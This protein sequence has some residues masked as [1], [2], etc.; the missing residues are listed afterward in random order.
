MGSN[1]GIQT[2]K[3]QKPMK[4]PKPSALPLRSATR[5]ALIAGFLPIAAQGATY[6][7]NTTPG[8]W[9][10]IVEWSDDSVAP[11]A[12]AVSTVLPGALDSVILNQ[13]NL[14]NVTTA[15]GAVGAV[16][17]SNTVGGT[18]L[19]TTLNI[20]SGGALEPTG[21]LTVG[22]N[23]DTGTLNVLA[24]GT[25]TAT[26]GIALGADPSH[27]LNVTGGEVTS[28]TGLTLSGGQFNL[29]SGTVT[30]TDPAPGGGTFNVMNG[31]SV[32]VLNVSG[33]DF[34]VA[35][36]LSAADTIA[37]RGEI[38]LSDGTFSALGGQA[39]GVTG[40]VFNIT[41]DDAAINIDRFNN[42][43]ASRAT[44]IN[45]EFDA[46]GVSPV[47][48]GGYMRLTHVTVNVDG[49]NYAGGPGVIN[50]MTSPN[51]GG[52]APLAATVTAP[53]PGLN[54][55]ISL[56]GNNLVVTLSLP[57]VDWDGSGDLTWNGPSDPTSWSG[58]TYNNGD[59]AYFSDT[60]AGAVTITGTVEPNGVVTTNSL[61]NDYTFTGVPIGGTGGLTKSG[62]GGLTLASANTYTGVTA[63]S[64]G[65]VSITDPAA[66]GADS[67][68]T[69]LSGGKLRISG[70]IT[71]AEP[72]TIASGAGQGVITGDA[73]GGILTGAVT[74]EGGTVDIRGGG[75]T[76]AGGVNSA[77]NQGLGL[78]GTMVIDT[79]PINLGTGRIDFT[80][81]GSNSANASQ[82][83]V[84]GNTW[85]ATKVA[86]GGFLRLGGTDYMPTTTSVV[87]GHGNNI[88]WNAAGIDLNGFDQAVAAL[89]TV[90]TGLGLANNQVITDTIGTGSLTVNV[91]EFVVQIYQGRLEGGAT[92]IKDGLGEFS[93][94][95]LSGVPN[96]N[97]GITVN[98]GQLSLL[99]PDLSDSSTV[100]ITVDDGL[101][102]D[103]V[104]TDQ[105]AALDLGSGPVVVEGTY[106]KPGSGASVETPRIIG[107]GLLEVVFPPISL[108]W[109]GSTD[110]NW[111]APDST[112]WSGGTYTDGD[113]AN[114]LGAGA[115]TVTIVGGVAPGGVVVN[116]TADYTL[117][118][119]SISGAGGLTKS[120]S[121]NLTLASANTYTGDT[122]VS[123]GRL[124]V[125]NSGSLGST[126][127]N[128]VVVNGASVSIEGG[129]AI[130]EPL[131][132]AGTG[133]GTGALAS[134]GNNTV[135]GAIIMTSARIETVDGTGKLILSGGVTGSGGSNILVGD[136][137]ADSLIDIGANSIAFAGSGINYA[138][139]GFDQG[140]VI[141]LNVADNI[142]GSAL[143]FFDANV[144]IGVN[145][146]IAFDSDMTFGFS[147]I[148]F[149]TAQLDLNGFDQQLASIATATNSLGVG[150]DVNITGGG[151]LT[152][153]QNTSTEYQGRITDGSTAT[154]LVKD[155]TGILTLN[156]LSGTPTSYTGD[157]Y[158]YGGT[159]AL[160]SADLAD[161]STVEIG[162]S[163]VLQL[164]HGNTDVVAVLVFG[165]TTMPAGTYNVGNSYGFITGSG[166]IQVGGGSIYDGWAGG[167]LPDLTDSTMSLDFDG[168][169][170][171]TGVEYVVGGDPT[172]ASDDSGL[173]PTS[174][175]SGSNLLFEFRRSDLA[176]NDSNTTIIVEYGSELTGWDTAVDGGAGV[177]ITVTD[178]FFDDGVDR[179]VV[180]LPTG[181]AVDGKLFARLN[182]VITE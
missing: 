179:V 33:G 36:A 37:F 27:S 165:S 174:S 105:V 22:A 132:L 67:G 155:G 61:S 116:S 94:E 75:I 54:S 92:L 28:P 119:A 139:A 177:I 135:S 98:L 171:E 152:V 117:T 148:D 4:I 126:A 182:V 85:G 26:G 12:F 72:I 178:D 70:G 88:N 80:S 44:E 176:N 144:K 154:S 52:V 63:I 118:G 39:F 99:A 9:A 160:N 172:D 134:D 137:Q 143:L 168:G 30:L 68:N 57:G 65:D 114:F 103:Y 136:I 6:V 7:R 170:L 162:G 146:A 150:G 96:S 78:N 42:S 71:V 34:I 159:L 16:Q 156:N 84:G 64:G 24:G 5:L 163:G 32:G 109:D 76:F 100:T 120:G 102:L 133:G 40:T 149:S 125:T 29:S 59:V 15:I 87:F 121:G 181:L 101:F 53:F 77:A 173:A 25:L 11:P 73:G 153:F 10:T 8:D 19:S 62:D 20:D 95:N 157:T 56:V 166:A 35:G 49:S 131:S 83:N 38:N 48:C 1:L 138:G 74:L 112:S 129:I 123:Q 145:D 89:E 81:N 175:V 91:P 113:A 18:F 13:D 127:G 47:A 51:S 97:A 21:V 45:F 151:T 17:I 169:G 147:A 124:T 115:G 31:G 167:F 86:F 130:A 14:T 164:D 79:T 41:G 158:V 108:V 82:L 60:G 128:T 46:T 43:V 69:I 3:N 104:G 180:S 110:T 55:A 111:S 93:M 50:L 2:L 140:N 107:D 106:G 142:W 122:L 66:L 90:T 141:A 23:T 161:G 58:D